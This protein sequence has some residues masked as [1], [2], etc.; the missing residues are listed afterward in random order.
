MNLNYSM[1]RE[2]D[3]LPEIKQYQ[4]WQQAYFAGIKEEERPDLPENSH[5]Q[6]YT[7]LC[8]IG[9]MIHAITV[10]GM[11]LSGLLRIKKFVAFFA[12]LRISTDRFSYEPLS[13]GYNNAYTKL[14]LVLLSQN[15]VNGAIKW[16]TFVKWCNFKNA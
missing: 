9:A 13:C 5:A 7:S 15:D 16:V 2:E 3:I 14:G 11:E 6:K 8:I 10:L 1:L 4:K 12:K